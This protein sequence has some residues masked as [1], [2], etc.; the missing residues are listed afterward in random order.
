M[1]MEK[2]KTPERKLISWMVHNFPEVVKNKFLGECKAIGVGPRVQLERIVKQWLAERK[3]GD[4]K[5]TRNTG[6]R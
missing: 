1:G 5:N 3:F 4:K 2:I 6:G